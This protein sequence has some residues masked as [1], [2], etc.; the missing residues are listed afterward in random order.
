VRVG[1]RRLAGCGDETAIDGLRLVTQEG[2]T[3]QRL[4]GKRLQG[5]FSS[6]AAS[7]V[8]FFK[9]GRCFLSVRMD[10]GG[11]FHLLDAFGTHLLV[12]EQGSAHLCQP[13]VDSRWQRGV[14]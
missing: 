3:Q 14:P 7:E 12:V 11:L 9:L 4:F 1:G 8:P 13:S 10:D 2:E 5:R 6:F